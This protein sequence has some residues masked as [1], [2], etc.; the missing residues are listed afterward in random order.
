MFAID[1]LADNLTLVVDIGRIFRNPYLFVGI[2]TDISIE[3][4]LLGVQ[5]ILA[6]GSLSIVVNLVAVVH[7]FPIEHLL[8]RHRIGGIKAFKSTQFVLVG[9]LGQRLLPVQVR[10]HR[11]TVLVFLNL[12]GLVATIGGIGQTLTKDGVADIVDKLA[13]HGV[14]N[15]ALVHPETLDRD[16]TYRSLLTP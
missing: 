12:I 2:D 16:V 10:L 11:V 15:F 6:F 1:G 9:L 5:T 14:G 8:T 7:L 13:I 4:T 3:Y